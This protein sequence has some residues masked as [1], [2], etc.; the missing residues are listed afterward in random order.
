MT[1]RSAWTAAVVVSCLL[2]GH[3]AFAQARTWSSEGPPRPL[4][5]RDVKFPSYEVRTL[6]NGLQ[7][8]VVE[9][10]E[11]PAVNMRLIIRAGSVRDPAGRQG[12]STLVASLLDQGTTTRGARAIADAIDSIGGDLDTGTGR[13]LSFLH[14][15]VMKD[16]FEFGMK[17]LSDVARNPAFDPAEIDRQRQQLL[18]ALKVSDDDPEYVANIVFDRVVYGF[19]PYG[20]PGNGTSDTVAKIRREDLVAYHTAYFVPNS[21]LLAVVGDLASE[22][23]FAMASRVFGDW[24]KQD[25]PASAPP[26]PPAPTRRVII[27]D[28]PDAV[29]TEVRVGQLGVPRKQKD[30]TPLDLAMRILG[31][32]GSNRIYRVLRTERGL[33]YGAEAQME[34]L[35][36]AGEFAV[37]TNTRSEAT[38]EVLR[39]IVDEFFRLRRERVDER[40]LDDAKAYLTGHFP[41]MLETPD[42]IATQVLN[43]LFYE[44]PLDEL[45]TFRQRTNA[46]SVDDIERVAIEYLRPDRLTVVLLGNAAAFANQLKGVGFGQYE[47]IPIHDIDLTRADLKQPSASGSRDEATVGFPVPA[48]R[49]VEAPAFKPAARSPSEVTR[50]FVPAQGQNLPSGL[51]RVDPEAQ[52]ILARAVEARG[53]LAKLQSIKTVVATAMTIVQTPQGPVKSETKTYVE[54]PLRF[55]VEAKIPGGETVQAYADGQAWVKGPDGRVETV[56]QEYVQR[57]RAP[58]E[59]DVLSLLVRASE[60]R[61]SVRVPKE[62]LGDDRPLAARRPLRLEISGGTFGS[63]TLS[64]DADTGFVTA[65]RYTEQG[66]MGPQDIEEVFSDYRAVDGVQVAFKAAIRSGTTT[67][68]ERAFSEIKFNVP[69][70]PAIF[71]RPQG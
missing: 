40:E 58:A 42:D 68:A 45:Q 29:Q 50:A 41:L 23:A 22:E 36:D 56:P 59:R 18:S 46:I 28:K 14:V 10:H 65:C 62:P 5:A 12:T 38:P 49:A 7:V 33:T 9:H 15:M 67:Y 44:L 21:S 11:Q 32:E 4:P 54:Y 57:F 39:L 6:P 52:R 35:K 24:K 47:V 17:L 16:S 19:H 71:K 60:G 2:S 1:R 63:V 20:F 8:V 61:L 13:D 48:P 30:F 26:A 3:Q 70:D 27:I 53:G 64:I 43:Q 31:G 69:V 34:T 51:A 37:V 55:R 25:V 66:G